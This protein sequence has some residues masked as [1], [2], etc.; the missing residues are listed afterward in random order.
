MTNPRR[1]QTATLILLLIAGSSTI[2]YPQASQ[3]NVL[4]PMGFA[5]NAGI[6]A[7][8]AG[9]F[10]MGHY[11]Y[12]GGM[13]TGYSTNF[14]VGIRI[15]DLSDPANPVLVGRIP[16]RTRGFNTNHSHGD[17]VA[18]HISSSVYE[19]D[20][21]IVLNG[22]PDNIAP[23][24]S[25]PQPYGLW[26]VSDPANPTFLSMLSFKM[27][28][29]REGGDLGDKPHDSKAVSGNYFYAVISGVGASRDTRVIVADLSDPRHPEIIGKWQD[30]PDVLLFG[31][32][33]N[34][35]GTRAYITGLYPPPYN[36]ESTTVY[37]YILNIEDPSNP[38][39]I[40]RYLLPVRSNETSPWIAR[41]TSD[42]KIVVLTDGGWGGQ[43]GGELRKGRCGI[44]HFLDT[45]DPASINR[46]ST[47]ELPE[48][49]S[50]ACTGQN[51]WYIA[52]D[53]AIRGDVVYSSWIAGGVRAI[54]ISDPTN[55]VEIGRFFNPQSHK[56]IS[57]VA[58][59][60]SDYV[61]ATAVWDAGLYVL[62]HSPSIASAREDDID[63]PKAFT[64]RQN[65]PNPFNPSTT[66]QYDLEKPAYARLEVFDV[67]GRTVAELVSGQLPAGRHSVVWDA[68]NQ[69]S[70][71]YF[72]RL[73]TEDFVETNSMFL[74]K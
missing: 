16:L 23:T 72:Y 43:K 31:L 74:A 64:L 26:D 20:V 69:S 53:V 50:G 32:A 19:G 56:D 29:M 1:T 45:S 67:F 70:G 57:D 4:K 48:S 46:I 71:V 27:G 12:V 21:A 24:G 42:D 62:S 2:A 65:Y 15:V 6:E 39:E 55:P 18:T 44:L 25:F 40:G 36:F 28:G 66:I 51:S 58:L 60:G 22:V 33:L 59:L 13:S 54:D 3:E 41:P 7:P 9:V 10:V 37:L 73:E 63:T 52:T 14:N 35:S 38:R 11:A 49:S 34:E 17:A 8:L 68:G 61:V 47:F 30:D 5:L